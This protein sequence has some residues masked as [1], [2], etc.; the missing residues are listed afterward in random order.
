[1]NGLAEV[2]DIWAKYISAVW[3]AVLI[4]RNIKFHCPAWRPIRFRSSII[5]GWNNA[6]YRRTLSITI[7]RISAKLWNMRSGPNDWKV[8]RLRIWSLYYEET[9]KTAS[10][11]S[12][13]GITKKE[14]SYNHRW[15]DFIC[16]CTTVI[17][18][19]WNMFHEIFR[20]CVKRE[21]T[22]TSWISPVQY[23]FVTGKRCKHER[24][25]GMGRA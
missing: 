8:I 10:S 5:S 14:P 20:N 25:S 4:S 21:T 23:Q 22:Q 7:M 11:E 24:T 2:K 18:F 15:D 9:A 17:L 6:E 3:E 16:D 19:P 12:N 1:M 13:T